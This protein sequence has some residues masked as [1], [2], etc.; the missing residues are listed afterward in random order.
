MIRTLTTT[1]A[2]LF[3]AGAFA[4]TM[5]GPITGATCVSTGT[6]SVTTTILVN[7]G[8]FDGG[9]KTYVPGPGMDINSH[10]ETIAAKSVLFRV[11]NG[12]K[13][14]NVIIDKSPLAYY[15]TARP[16]HVYSGATLENVDIRQF[17][18]DRAI[19]IRTAGTVNI[20]KLTA[21]NSTDAF[22][23]AI[24]I[25]TRVNVTN[26]VFKNARK[27]YRQNGGTTYPTH[28]AISFCDISDMT[29]EIFRTDSASAS[30]NLV[31]SRLHN[32][33]KVCTGYAEG[34]CVATGNVVY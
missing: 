19:G 4:Q 16:I 9:C 33:K 6:V 7:S 1:F 22:I 5:P 2:C 14:R 8:I 30:A 27:V 26:C 31:N 20:T 32:F 11:E 25:N 34:R 12:A 17:D 24:G 21:V 29:D 3:A 23:H 13:L 10:S 28:A 15:A 18:G